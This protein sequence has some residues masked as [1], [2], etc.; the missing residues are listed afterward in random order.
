[1]GK[2]ASAKQE[3]AEYRMSIHVGVGH[4]LD[5]VTEIRVDEKVAWSG[6]VEAN[7]AVNI[8]RPDL[9]GGQRKEGG[10]VGTV[11]FLMGRDDQ[12]LPAAAAARYRLAPND[13]PAFRGLTTLMF[14]GS[15][16]VSTGRPGE[17]D[18]SLIGIITGAM[19]ET[20]D[21]SGFL[22]K[23]N[24]PVIA[25]KIEVT[26]VRAPKGL[27]PA[28]AMIGPDANGIHIIYECLTNDEWG[29]GGAPDL[30]NKA[31]FEA[32]A[33]RLKN[34]A[35]GLSL[36]WM[37]QQTIEAFIGEILDHIQATIFVN[38]NTGLLDVKLLRDDYDIASLRHIT[39]D[40]AVLTNFKRRSSGEIVNEMTVAFTNPETEKSESITAQDIASIESQDGQKVAGSRD[41]YAIRN[42][43]L[44]TTVL[45]RDLRASTAPLVSADAKLDRSGW[46]VIPG[47]VMLLSWPRRN[48]NAI[49]VRAGKVSYGK[50]KDSAI[51]VSL[52][53]DVFSLSKPVI[54]VLPGS[55]WQDPTVDP[56]P[57][58]MRL[59]TVPAFFA[60][61][62]EMQDTQVDL[63]PNEAL[64][65]ALADSETYDSFDYELV[66]ESV[67]AN[68]DTV[69]TSKGAMSMT[70][71]AL[72]ADTM[73]AAAVSV[74][75]FALFPVAEETPRVGGFAFIGYGD[76]NQEIALVTGRTTTGWTIARGVLDTVP[77]TWAAGTPLWLINPGAR[78]VD[79]QTVYAEGSIATYRGL[80]RTARGVLGYDD[81]PSVST[82]VTDRAHLPL[83]PAN[84][85]LNGVGFGST[86]IGSASSVQLSWSIRNRLVED[87]VVQLWTDSSTQPEY[88]QETVVAVYDATTETLLREYRWLWT[89]TGVSFPRANLERYTSLRFV[90]SSRRDD[91]ISLTSHAIT[92]TG[93]AG[94]P[95]APDLPEAL[96]RTEPPVFFPAPAAGAFIA[97]AGSISGGDG[98]FAPTI[99][100]SGQQ[101]I[102]DPRFLV[103]RLRPQVFEAPPIFP[104]EDYE[105]VRINIAW[106]LGNPVPINQEQI[107]FTMGGLLG[108]TTYD[109]QVAYMVD[110]LVG[111][112]REIGPV[113]TSAFVAGSLALKAAQDLVEEATKEVDDKI[114]DAADALEAALNFDGLFQG[115]DDLAEAILKLGRGQTELQR[116]VE[117][118]TR[119]GGRLVKSIVQ[120]MGGELANAQGAIVEE[121][122]LSL[123]RDLAEGGYRQ[124]LALQVNENRVSAET[125]ISGLV[126]DVTA[127]AAALA[128]MGIRVD[129]GEAA[130]SNEAS[131]R[132]TE[133]GLLAQTLGLLGVR[134]PTSSGFILNQS[135]VQWGEEGTLAQV[136][137]GLRAT[138]GLNSSSITTLLQTTSDQA[139][140]LTTISSTVAENTSSVSMLLSSVEGL[141]AR[142]TLG[143]FVNGAATALV[144][145]GATRSLAFS[146]SSFAI[147]DDGNGLSY[148]PATGRLQIERGDRKIF[149]SASGGVGIWAG[150]RA[151]ADGAETVDNGTF[152]ISDDDAFFGGRTLAGFF[153]PAVS[154]ATVVLS[155]T[156]WANIQSFEMRVRKG[157]FAFFGWVQVRGAGVD[158][159]EGP[160][161]PEV[162]VRIVSMNPDG[163]DV[164]ELV[165]PNFVNGS[166]T[167]SEWVR[168][169][170]AAH[171]RVM[172]DRTGTRR[173]VMQARRN[174]PNT[175][176]AEA[177]SGEM[178]FYYLI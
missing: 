58:E 49:V 143:L 170:M 9:F 34:E 111:Q 166:L 52:M 19:G 159:G 44:A 165:A 116:I 103:C 154:D 36:W 65:G 69:I 7:L 172:N 79:T 57:L 64:V 26:G 155:D 31:G 63:G 127:Q 134:T 6:R 117:T 21:S 177:R 89:E 83:R 142:W 37:R 148:R 171:V 39:P 167:N 75:P 11:Q 16:M 3:V 86:P 80:D 1:M 73:P 56:Q 55:G 157:G 70:P 68:G 23:M 5:A 122:R 95:S 141:G 110:D 93:L 132:G 53:Q 33:L 22:W 150:S 84:V 98:S 74:I 129:A 50:P 78:I 128:A 138:D 156:V 99:E 87:S 151:I 106:S 4:A 25:Q 102:P 66:S 35:F 51:R 91:S 114:K 125:G 176:Y 149:L 136:L 12:V 126:T 145:D 45:A 54:T 14:H 130:L 124:A 20:Y 173:I 169:Q 42:R 62:A 168:S 32:Q 108:E 90:V 174:G 147:I 77:K 10:L 140:Q 144:A 101:D 85:R 81:A 27:D 13:C 119:D 118:H 121:A 46:D 120:V 105:P 82:L 40:N 43:E 15:G 61:N 107:H 18:G 161:P 146:G 94:D 133:T 104:P 113:T 131:V 162:H 76:D 139:S 153:S 123:E 163:S 17:W 59:F 178:Q 109:V 97:E 112:W 158:L 48:V 30:I 164:V 152:G 88:R 29:M 47:E 71:L 96:D 8:N 175:T 137:S 41:Y 28:T 135:T 2:G 67:S 72:L 160:V 115:Q 92:V 24:S 60:R 38:P 100:I